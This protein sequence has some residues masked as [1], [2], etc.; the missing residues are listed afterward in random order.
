MLTSPWQ[1][2]AE[3][4]QSDDPT[5]VSTA[6]GRTF[7][8][9][10]GS[11]LRL[12]NEAMASDSRLAASVMVKDCKGVFGAGRRGGPDRHGG[13]GCSRCFSGVGV[14]RVGSPPCGCRFE[15]EWE[16]EWILHDWSDEESVK[17]LKRCKEALPSRGGKVI[18]IDIKVENDKEGDVDESTE[19]QLFW[20]MLRMIVVMGEGENRE[21]LGEALHQCRLQR[22]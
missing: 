1:N 18:I 3:W 10:V 7:W 4:F 20:D 11:D 2:V 21:R 12:F 16:L 9:H 5:P 14:H 8:E 17:I 6:H 22:L 15:R 13:E 19:T